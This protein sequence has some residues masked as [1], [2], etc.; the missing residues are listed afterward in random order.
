MRADG[1]ITID[2]HVLEAADALA[3]AAKAVVTT[4][5]GKTVLAD[6]LAAYEKVRLEAAENL[7]KADYL[8]DD[9]KLDDLYQ[10]WRKACGK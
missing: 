5:D 6:A 7:I 4:H 1:M 3:K 9:K 10:A 8:G 2:I